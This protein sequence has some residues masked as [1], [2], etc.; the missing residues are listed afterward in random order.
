[1]WPRD[2]KFGSLYRGVFVITGY[3]ISGFLPIKI[4]VIFLGSKNYF[5][6]TG[7][8]FYRGSTVQL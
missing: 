1:M 8:S 7:T 4:T 5:V 6:I 2:P 3:I